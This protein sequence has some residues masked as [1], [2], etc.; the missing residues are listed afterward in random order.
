[1]QQHIRI[2]STLDYRL[3][4]QHLPFAFT[5]PPGATVLSIRFDYEPKQS[6]GQEVGNDLSLTLFDPESARGARHN[7]RQRDLRITAHSATVGSPGTELEFA[8]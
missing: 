5:M 6:Q 8:L 3:N 7:N 1:M 2:D 4:K